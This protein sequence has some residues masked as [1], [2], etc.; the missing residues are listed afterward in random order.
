MT[1]LPDLTT[2]PL[3]R[4]E[5]RGDAAAWRASVERETGRSAEDFAWQTMEGL[6]VRPLYT[7]EDLQGLEHL[8][9][10]AGLPP[11]LRGPY[12]TMYV[13]PALDRPPVRRL[14]HRRGVATPSTG[15]TWRPD[16]RASRSPSTSPRTAATTPTTRASSATSARPAWPSTRSST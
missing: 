16:R 3:K 2:L 10:T 9:F 1:A 11:F 5:P 15:A 7:R 8:G 14:L 4:P 6:D 13:M 12:A